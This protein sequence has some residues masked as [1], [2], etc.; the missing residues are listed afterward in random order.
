MGLDI[1]T[2][3]GD[4]RAE[5]AAEGRRFGTPDVLKQIDQC[6]SGLTLYQADLSAHGFT[7]EDAA[8]LKAVEAAMRAQSSERS[9]VRAEKKGMT[10]EERSLLR[11]AQGMRERA[12]TV[13]LGVLDDL[14]LA[15]AA[16]ALRAPLIVALEET[17]IK[18]KVSGRA[19]EQ[20][21]HL[22]RALGEA[23]VEA[24]VKAR[25]GEDLAATL[26]AQADALQA[27]AS[28]RTQPQGTPQET[29]ALN[30]LDGLAVSLLRRARRAAQSASRATGNRAIGAAFKLSHLY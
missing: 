29:E 30:V 7:V 11:E 5:L 26:R 24:Q 1:S 19:C 4:V 13:A 14:R 15:G 2:M 20:L 17:R 9:G 6:Q 3:P 8:R 23:A 22:A 10:L 12:R 18:P 28:A 16:Q 27:L 21:T 25:G